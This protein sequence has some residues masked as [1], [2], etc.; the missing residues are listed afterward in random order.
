[1]KNVTLLMAMFLVMLSACSGD[2]KNYIV[3]GELPDSSFHGK[4]IYAYSIADERCVDSAVVDGKILSFRGTAPD[5]AYTC[6][7]GI[8]HAFYADFVLEEGGD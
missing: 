8:S 3:R 4:T 2:S 6:W 5:T 1:M 7:V